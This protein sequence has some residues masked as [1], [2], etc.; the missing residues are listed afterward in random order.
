MDIRA[1]YIARLIA[2]EESNGTHHVLHLAD[3]A[4]RNFLHHSCKFRLRRA[5]GIDKARGNCIDGDP[6]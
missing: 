4:S 1:V 2:E 3:I 6:V 5:P